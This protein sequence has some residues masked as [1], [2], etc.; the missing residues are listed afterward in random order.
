MP[1]Q[2][3][4]TTVQACVNERIYQ[5]YNSQ[6]STRAALNIKNIGKLT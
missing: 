4:E 6:E 3:D 5:D 1:S 2:A